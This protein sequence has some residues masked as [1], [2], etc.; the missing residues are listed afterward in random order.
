[1]DVDVAEDN[2]E[3]ASKRRRTDSDHRISIDI[4][5]DGG[6]RGNPGIAGAGAEVV[7]EFKPLGSSPTEKILHVRKFLGRGSTNNVAEYWGVIA[8]LEAALPH[9]RSF[10][11]EIRK[12]SCAATVRLRGDSQLVLEQL[13][14]RYRCNDPKLVPLNRQVKTLLKEMNQQMVTMETSYKHVKREHNSKADGK[15]LQQT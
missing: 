4:S 1:M 7:L 12:G 2:S 3:L 10:T 11:K 13:A 8:A 5:F 15:Y 6:S 14:G 9:V